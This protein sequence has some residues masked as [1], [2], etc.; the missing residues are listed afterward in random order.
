[1]VGGLA[2]VAAAGLLLINTWRDLRGYRSFDLALVLGTLSLP[3]LS[4]LLVQV[5]GQDPVNY[6]PP[7]VYYSGAITALVALASLAIGLL[8]DRRR[9]SFVAAIHYGILA[10]LFTTFFTNGTGIATGLVGSLGYWLAQQ[11]VQRGGQPWYY[12]LVVAPLY[13]YLPIGSATHTLGR[14][15]RGSPCTWPYL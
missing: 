12:Y 14:R 9:W 4:P 6:E 8:W 3:F 11:E 13:E 7:T 5:I 1:V 2:L 15:C 10:V